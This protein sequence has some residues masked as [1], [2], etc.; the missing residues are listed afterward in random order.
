MGPQSPGDDLDTMRGRSLVSD[1][2]AG[3]SLGKD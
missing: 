3:D 2:I 1:D